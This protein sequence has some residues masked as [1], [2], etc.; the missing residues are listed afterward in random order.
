MNAP[1]PDTA[2]GLKL[3]R[4]GALAS[5][6]LDRPA[7]LNAVDSGM[8]KAI[9]A[10]LPDLV[11]DPQLYAIVI[12][13]S[14]AKVFCAGGDIRELHEV[15][16]RDPIEAGRML[17]DEYALIW[18]L[19]CLPKPS[20]ALM[21][22]AAMGAGAGLSLTCTHRVAGERYSFQMPET[23]I[24]FFPDDGVCHAF[25][26]MPHRI[27]EYLA[28]TGRAIG[29]ADA[30]RLGLVTHCI[31]A[32]RFPEIE[33][34]LAEAEPIDQVLEALHVPP[35]PA[36][37]DRYAE[38]IDRCFAG[39][40][41]VAIMELL[42]AEQHD[43]A[44]CASVLAELGQRSPLALQ[45][46]L[47][48]VRR[49]ANLDLRQTLIADHRIACRLVAAPDFIEGVRAAVIAKD[50]APR[51]QPRHVG[52]VGER[53]V[54]RVLAAMPAAELLLPTRQEMRAVRS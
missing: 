25:S 27:G 11:R 8:R 24:G 13:A 37:I 36:G 22:G 19:D 48:Q 2:V 39:G 15:A 20:L 10:A 51:W 23:A 52:D 50:G 41:V 42:A 18:Q 44:W 14:P 53:L 17:A 46:T 35:G 49:A 28:L 26:R 47:A 30:L 7:K 6:V 29:P 1:S 31:P 5:L 4:R 32:A 3:E 16:R 21:D 9:A 45:V 54:I 40:D 34:A 38:V 12:K 33:A 43:K